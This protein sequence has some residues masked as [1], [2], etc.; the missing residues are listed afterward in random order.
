MVQ[1]RRVATRPSPWFLLLIGVTAAGA[2]LAVL[3]TPQAVAVSHSALLTAGLLL[4]ILGG[5]AVT[6]CLHEFGHAFTAYRFGDHTVVDRGYLTLDI[7]RY[8]DL[9]LS[10]LL[11]LV[12]LLLG[13]IP[14]P[15]GAVFINHHLIG[16]PGRRSLVSLAGPSAN[17]VIGLGLIAVAAAVPMPVG[18]LVGVSALAYFQ[19]LAFFLNILPIPGLDGFGVIEPFVAPRGINPQ[20]RSW[21]PIVFFL[22]LLGFAPLRDLVFGIGSGLF[23]FLGGDV[24]DAGRGLR[25]MQFW[26][27]ARW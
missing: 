22:L 8:T 14:L 6:L 24:R 9:G 16:S 5:W 18:L 17:L 26:T 2:V 13:G 25:E 27:W 1:V 12:F 4:F 23:E 20:I 19:I 15:G 21:A 10:F 7:R 11:P 3:G